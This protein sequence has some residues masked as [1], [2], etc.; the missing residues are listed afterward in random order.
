MEKRKAEG[1]KRGA[2]SDTGEGDGRPCPVW[3]AHVALFEAPRLIS[4]CVPA[5][6]SRPSLETC[7]DDVTCLTSFNPFSEEDE[8]DQSP[9]ALVSSLFSKVK[10]T[11]SAPRSAAPLSRLI[12]S[13]ER[14][15]SSS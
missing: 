14:R 11:L 10:S 5:R 1:L 4:V 12:V 13:R 3:R 9:Y 15:G 8:H 2:N 6:C 7:L